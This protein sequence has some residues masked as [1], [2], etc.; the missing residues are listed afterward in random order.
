[1]LPLIFINPFVGVLLWSWVSFM[2]PQRLVWG[3]AEALP[4]ALIIGITGILGWLASGRPRVPGDRTTWLIALFVL[5]FTISTCFALVPDAA[6][7]KWW[8]VTKSFV[9]LFIT[10]ALLTNR[11]RVH[12]LMWVMVISIGFY[13]IKGGIFV[14]E[15]GGNYRIW[16]PADTVIGDNNHIACALVV[17]LPLI[18]YLVLQSKTVALRMGARA[19]MVLSLLAAL[20]SYS[21]GAFLALGVVATAQWW[22]SRHKVVSAVVIFAALSLAIG[23]MPPAWKDRIRSIETYQDDPSV[24]HRFDIWRASTL[25]ALARP[26]TG[27]GFK[28]PY[29]QDVVSRY[30]PGVQARAVH[31]IWFEVIGENG[32]IAFFIWIAIAWTALANCR[33]VRWLTKNDPELSWANDLARMIEVSLFGFFV[34]GTFLS[35]PYWDFYFTLVVIIAAVRR[36]VVAD[37]ETEVSP[38]AVQPPAPF[39]RRTIDLLVAR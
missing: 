19:A 10:A 20:S 38:T 5:L 21:R 24:T 31:S 27:G 23:F 8:E 4:F 6:W 25:I 22:Q 36:I 3:P 11:V 37:L 14:L 29:N 17:I 30:A 15:T 1:M 32:F 28:A 16:G 18:N 9:Y 13:G 33:H 34:G 39:G 35:L 7:P 2:S 12:A 26:L